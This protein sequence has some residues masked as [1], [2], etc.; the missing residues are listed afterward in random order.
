MKIHVGE[1]DGRE[2]E[3]EEFKTSEMRNR[4]GRK[5][6]QKEQISKGG[7]GNQERSRMDGGKGED[8]VYYKVPSTSGTMKS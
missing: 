7:Q 4:Q 8:I 5:G 3:K 6:S 1:G 2:V